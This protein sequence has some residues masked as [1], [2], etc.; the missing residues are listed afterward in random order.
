[1]RKLIIGMAMAA[2][3][4]TTAMA[5][6]AG[7]W[8]CG[9]NFKAKGKGFQVLVGKFTF[10]GKGTM[11]CRNML[12][13]ESREYNVKVSMGSSIVAP[14]VAFGSMKVYGLA[15]DINIPNEPDRVFGSYL[16]TH[17]QA[18]VGVG[19]GAYTAVAL[20]RGVTLNLSLQMTTGFGVNVGVS[21]MK[22][23]NADEE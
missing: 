16:V 23:E 8:S 17:A 13:G 20:H 22:I 1:M 18:A 21:T 2:L 19:G 15:K 11:R 14:R 4:S 7:L 10:D 12:N 5:H 6:D 3:F 9:L